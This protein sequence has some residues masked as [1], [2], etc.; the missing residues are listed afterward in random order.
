M[1]LLLW[2]D[3][4]PPLVPQHALPLL[5]LQ[6]LTVLTRSQCCRALRPLRLS[7]E[8]YVRKAGE[9]ITDQVRARELSRCLLIICMCRASSCWRCCACCCACHERPA[10]LPPL[11]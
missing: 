1:L 7:E 10:V 2:L 9:E 5:L 6:L 3:H 4:L 11:V 8:L